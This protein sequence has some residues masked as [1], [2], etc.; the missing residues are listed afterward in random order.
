MDLIN[1]YVG[2]KIA[3]HSL[4]LCLS[5]RIQYRDYRAQINK[6]LVQNDEWTIFMQVPT[7]HKRN[8]NTLI[9]INN[10]G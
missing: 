2:V 8:R 6:Y 4:T 5:I 9:T 7:A 3:C 1:N 10:D